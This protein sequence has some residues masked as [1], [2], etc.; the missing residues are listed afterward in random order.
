MD[1]LTISMKNSVI[2]LKEVLEIIQSQ[3]GIIQ[4]GI[5]LSNTV[6]INNLVGI[7]SIKAIVYFVNFDIILSSYKFA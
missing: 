6:W 5:F 1:C 4:K 7:M 3:R 2:G